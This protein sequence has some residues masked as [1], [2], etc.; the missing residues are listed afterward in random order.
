VSISHPPSTPADRSQT[1]TSGLVRR[2]QAE[3]PGG[4]PR[5]R[6][7]VPRLFCVFVWHAIRFSVGLVDADHAIVHAS[8]MHSWRKLELLP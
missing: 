1:A 7:E 3:I 5:E 6:E 4:L 2:N 8:Q